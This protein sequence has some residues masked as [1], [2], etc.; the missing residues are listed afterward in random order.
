MKRLIVCLVLAAFLGAA[1]IF[2]QGE[3]PDNKKSQD[4]SNPPENNMSRME[5][6]FDRHKDPRTGLIPD[7]IRFR[8]ALFVSK[9]PGASFN[10][11]EKNNSILSQDWQRRGP[12]EV[13]G[14][15]RALAIDVMDENIILAGGVSGGMW[16]STDGGLS[17]N[18]TTT[19]LQLHSVSCITQDTRIG[20]ENTWY[21]GTGEFYGNSAGISG[22]GIYK[23]TD[24][25][26]SWNPILSTST[27]V[28]QSWENNFDYI[29]RIVI[30]HKN[31]QQDEI[32]AATALGGIFR[33]TD[34]GDSWSVVLGGYGNTYSYFSELIITPSGVLYATLSQYSYSVS[35][36][37]KGIYRSTDGIKWTNI[38][39][40]D[41]PDKYRRI[42]PAYS[43]SNENIVYFAAETPGHGKLTTNSMGDSLWH[44]FWKYT[45]LSGD[46][47]NTGGKWENRS[48]N[49]PKPNL[50]RHHFNTQG[51]Y[52]FTMKVKPDDPET[53]IIGAVNLYRTTDGLKTTA[54][55]TLIGGTCPE[56]GSL[57]DCEYSYRYPNH[58]ADQ[59]E[60]LFSKSNPNVIYTGSD[61]GIHKTLDVMAKDVEWI[62][63]NNSYF[64][65]QFYTCAVDHTAV[66]D[67]IIGGLQDNGTLFT[68]WNDLGKSWT[69]PCN[70]D[71]FHCAIADNGQHYYTSQNSSYQPKIKIFSNKLDKNGS[72]ISS[73]RIDPVGGDSFIWNTPFVLDPNDN[74]IMYLCGG[75]ILWRNSDLSKI[76]EGNVK[77]STSIGW[78]SINVHTS[79]LF[80]NEYLS[81]VEASKKPAN[82][83]YYGTTKG[84]LFK[85]SESNTSNYKFTNVTGKNF[86]SNGY[87]SSIAIDPFDAEKVYVT[88]SNYSVLSIFY[89]ANGGTDWIPV[90]GNLEANESGSG[91]GPAVHHL[92]IVPVN[93]NM[94]YFAATS[95]GLF[96]TAYID[97][98]Y[99]VWQMEGPE[100]IG[101]M[102]I[103]MIDSRDED[104]FVAVATHG[105]GMFFTRI[106]GLPSAPGKPELVSP[107]DNSKG[108]LKSIELSWKPVPGAYY[109]KLQISSSPN[110]SD[111]VTEFDGIDTT[112]F[113]LN[114]VEQGFKEFYWRV[115]AKSSGG[116][117]SPSDSRKFTSAIVSPMLIAP[118]NKENGVLIP[119]TLKWQQ[120]AGAQSYNVLLSNNMAFTNLLID[121]SGIAGSEL[122]VSTLEKGKKYYWKVA[123]FDQDGTG[124]YSSYFTFTTEP[125]NYV[126]ELNNQNNIIRIFPNP[127]MYYARIELNIDD[128]GNIKIEIIDVTGGIVKS[129]I[130]TGE[131]KGNVYYNLDASQL[132][133]G[134]YF[135]TAESL[136]NKYVK[137]FVVEK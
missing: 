53:V 64:T 75:R 116:I 92:E 129:N 11:K 58:H 24:G 39:P 34:G 87:V 3:K 57:S 114:D 7:D 119:V 42:I 118:G 126:S 18:K 79:L 81:A 101:N 50:I 74:N 128:P 95:A 117:S 94:V 6:E 59:H 46:G 30:N 137:K 65:T 14:R 15:T 32:Y 124:L 22:D 83:V 12:A 107:A 132:K 49:L 85:L 40:P 43:P 44:C 13:G 80:A 56:S 125:P 60:V 4:I 54:N 5:W 16:R 111:Y 104:D 45:Y 77:D 73:T 110:F 120:V 1:L 52:N 90:S 103:N 20:K 71:G 2:T 27:F 112:S 133:A 48:E 31:T 123:S 29:W 93:G 38:T 131:F 21:Y 63:L 76:P 62:S 33:S 130:I 121:T 122:Q 68:R 89:S 134:S 37:V 82:V 72:V 78:D 135:I 19:P 102:V 61:G 47:S 23:S 105:A 25:G 99:T 86:P 66:N 35:S 109:Y 98:K 8:E 69:T 26:K 91:N 70:G 96:S 41:M 9:L 136:N 115:Y 51:S 100:S 17:W 28:P 113:V 88:F 55:T 108:I 106:N 84:K 10:I 97:G 127:V 67:E 36:Q